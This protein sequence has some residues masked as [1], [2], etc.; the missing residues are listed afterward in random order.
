D[1]QKINLAENVD[2]CSL[3][4]I[5][6][7]DRIKSRVRLLTPG[8][9][10]MAT[11]PLPPASLSPQPLAPTVADP[12]ST[13]LVHDKLNRGPH[14]IG[15]F[16]FAALFLVGIVYALSNLIFDVSRVHHPAGSAYLLLGVALLV[17]LGF[18]FVNGFHTPQMPLRRSST[19]IR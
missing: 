15:I 2:T 16:V 7:P 4:R 14:K 17:A 6:S 12:R 1:S 10:V 11:A 18:E 13:A 8:V 19:P 3:R 9:I 5:S